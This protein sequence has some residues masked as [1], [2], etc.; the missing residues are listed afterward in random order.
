MI[1]GVAA[2]NPTCDYADFN[3]TA[4]SVALEATDSIYGLAMGCKLA[5]LAEDT[6]V[7]GD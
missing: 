1:A 4:N 2:T 6:P 7:I 5:R 3:I